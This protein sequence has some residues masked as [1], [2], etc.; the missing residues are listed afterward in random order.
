MERTQEYIES[1][2]KRYY[3]IAKGNARNGQEVFENNALLLYHSTTDGLSYHIVEIDKDDSGSD[4][5]G[6]L[7]EWA[8]HDIKERT[9]EKSFDEVI[10]ALMGA[11]KEEELDDTLRICD[12]YVTLDCG[13]VIPGLIEY[14]EIIDVPDEEGEYIP[15]ATAGDYS[16]SCPWNA[17]GMN[18]RDFG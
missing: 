3:C 14:T 18:I 10:Y 17:P 16:P 8:F 1:A 13:Y 12:E 7:L 4:D 15:S 5:I 2:R 11:V 9:D 6:A